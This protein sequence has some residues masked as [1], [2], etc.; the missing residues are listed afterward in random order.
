[1]SWRPAIVDHRKEEGMQD[2]VLSLRVIIVAIGGLVFGILLLLSPYY[3]TRDPL[4]ISISSVLGSFILSYGVVTPIHN[5]FLWKHQVERTQEVLEASLIAFQDKIATSVLSNVEWV[6]NIQKYGIKHIHY[7]MPRDDI[8][9]VIKNAK[10]AYIRFL[11]FSYGLI[12]D[13]HF[14]PFKEALANGCKIEILT[15]DP[16]NNCLVKYCEETGSYK[17]NDERYWA[18]QCIR[19][20]NRIKNELPPEHKE[21]F[22][23]RMYTTTTS[24]VAIEIGPPG[25]APDHIWFGILWSHSQSFQGPWFEIEGDDRLATHIHDHIDEIKR[26][27]PDSIVDVV[28]G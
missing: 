11:V 13:W 14:A 28:K 21:N 5:Y 16:D 3:F 9:N 4:W 19:S 2:E 24:I 10:N 18:E 7:D 1:V 6:R 12:R 17:D 15:A 20:L 25:K 26:R 22:N 23:F 8:N 27:E